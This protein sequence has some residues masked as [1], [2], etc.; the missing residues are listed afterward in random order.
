MAS[1]E[2]TIIA[3]LEWG[4]LSGG[5]ERQLEDVA[6]LER[7]SGAELDLDHL[8]HWVGELGLTGLW[9]AVRLAVGQ[10]GL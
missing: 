9:A 8:E 7:L 4:G 1:V 2:D 5:S 3:K 6:Q 10:Q